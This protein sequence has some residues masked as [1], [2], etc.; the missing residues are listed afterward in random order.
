[1]KFL[2]QSFF[3]VGLLAASV[4]T[5][6]DA[7]PAYSDP[8]PKKYDIT[9]R[10]S[11]IDPRAKEH[12]EIDFVF[13]KDGKPSDVE[14]G[15]VDTRVAPQGKLVIWLM[16]Y[17]GQ[18]FDR[19]SGYGLHGI[20]VHYAN[21]WFGKLNKEPPPDDKYLGRIRL[22]ASTGEDHSDAIEIPKPD[23]MMERAYQLVKHL[24]KEHPQGKWEQFLSKDGKGL[25]WDK[26]IMSGSSHGSTTS[27]RFALHQK[28][29]RVVMFSGPRSAG[30]LVFTAVGHR[31]EPVLRV[32]ACSRYRLERRPL[33]PVVAAPGAQQIRPGGECRQDAGSL[34]Q[35]AAADHGCGSEV[36]GPGQDGARSVDARRLGHQGAGREVHP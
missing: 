19:I 24:S 7:P 27:A 26:V 29:D 8:A 20:Q 3:L 21:G 22:E 35:L 32:Y 4:A 17:N 13:A 9:A 16:G 18:L 15:V 14:H 31:Q 30:D 34:R 2:P 10:A 33:L 12:P 23:G 25:N 36:E 28:V 1:M 5:A 11:E 6:A